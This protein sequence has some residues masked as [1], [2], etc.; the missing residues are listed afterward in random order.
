[1]VGANLHMIP[2]SQTYPKHFVFKAIFWKTLLRMQ[3]ICH[4][5][6][7]LYYG[8]VLDSG[9]IQDS[10]EISGRELL[11]ALWA[12]MPIY[13]GS[14]RISGILFF[15][16]EKYDELENHVVAKIKRRHAVKFKK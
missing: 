7:C 9:T 1:M 10:C 16:M 8:L 3:S 14:S 15:T 6:F 2:L 12:K 4:N 5:Y 11:D 13:K